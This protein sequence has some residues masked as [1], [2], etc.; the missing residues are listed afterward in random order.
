MV[1]KEEDI[2]DEIQLLNGILHEACEGDVSNF[3]IK[4][5]IDRFIRKIA[6]FFWHSNT[7]VVVVRP[8]YYRKRQH[9][10]L[11]RYPSHLDAWRS[12]CH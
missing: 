6:Y 5:G 9:V 8:G 11:Y 1:I 12:I 4:I 10:V 3:V 2:H 7:F